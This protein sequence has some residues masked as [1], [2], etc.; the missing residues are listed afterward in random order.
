MRISLLRIVRAASRRVGSVL[1][2][3][4]ILLIWKIWGSRAA[5]TWLR[6]LQGPTLGLCLQIMGAKVGQRVSFQ[7]HLRIMNPGCDLSNL[8]IDH[9]A[10]IGLDCLFDLAGSIEIGKNAVLSPSVRILTH[11]DVGNSPLR[12]IYPRQVA[13]VRVGD[14]AYVGTGCTLL[15]GVEIGS[16]AVIAAG[17]VV[18]CSVGSAEVVGGVPARLLRRVR[19]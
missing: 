13:G 11:Q 5:V 1:W 9:G 17:A 6:F 4:W 14:G 7:G 16:E 10:H 8:R 18:V 2:T 3:A 12:Y 15:A 19:S